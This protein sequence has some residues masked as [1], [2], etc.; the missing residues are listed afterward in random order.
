[1]I[2]LRPRRYLLASCLATASALLPAQEPQTEHT[3]ARLLESLERVPVSSDGAAPFG[4]FQQGSGRVHAESG[5][6]RAEFTADA[7]AL[8][9]P[10]EEKDG[11]QPRLELRY[12]NSSRSGARAQAPM[13]TPKL[14]GDYVRYSRDALVETYEVR[15]GGYEQ[16]FHI[17]QRPAGSGDLVIAIAVAGNVTAPAAEA[18]HQALE[19]R[20]GEVRAIRYGEA[21]AFD[22]HGLRTEVL[23][24]YDGQGRLELIVPAS[25]VDGATYPI[26]VDPWVGPVFNPG[27]PSFED[28]KPDVAYDLENDSYMVVWQREF[29][30]TNIGIRAQVFDGDGNP[31]TG[32]L[33][34]EAG[35]GIA[36][37]AVAFSH[38]LTSNAFLIV[39]ESPTGIRGQMRH[40][41]N[42]GSFASAFAI[43]SPAAGDIDRRPCVS[44]PGDPTMMV[45]WDR[46][47]SG[48]SDA[49]LILM[50]DL[51]WAVPTIPASFTKS[52]ERNLYTVQGGG[53][54]ERVRLGRSDVRRQVGSENWFANRA[55]W[56]RWY[57]TPLP[58]DWDVMTC[59][60]A[61]RP[62]PSNFMFLQTATAVA[63]TFSQELAP[64]IA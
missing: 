12:L 31:S 59:S 17:D 6:F 19:F 63:G 3:P 10:S 53:K 2:N 11:E 41:T 35:A 52:P 16:S 30:A 4:V 15:A 21:I 36:N 49:K 23:T 33:A 43:S 55:V 8:W 34:I 46:Q 57:T 51:Y 25:F 18:R 13:V 62:T 39:W 20:H 22:R 29:S 26:V 50:H 14:A 1:M 42:G 40:S 32:L 56:Q 60:F 44:G 28:I 45:A 5:R 24:R 58:G 47:P 64:D 61:V 38:C 9:T 48:Q 37:P 54:V 7:V 27:G